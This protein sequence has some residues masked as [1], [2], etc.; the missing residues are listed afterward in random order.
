MSFK[1]VGD[2]GIRVPRV[3]HGF[4]VLAKRGMDDAHV[5]QDLGGLGDPVKLLQCLVELVVVIPREGGDPG[6]YFLVEAVSKRE[7]GGK[8]R[9]RRVTTNLFQ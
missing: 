4:L 2:H 6:F 7:F 1:A 5:E 9:E 3:T 8:F